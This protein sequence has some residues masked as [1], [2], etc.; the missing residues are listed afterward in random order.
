MV[1]GNVFEIKIYARA[2]N[3]DV[4]KIVLKWNLNNIHIK[5]LYVLRS[6]DPSYRLTY[7]GLYAEI[8]IATFNS[9]VKLH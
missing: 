9:D 8:F 7:Y 2:A 6:W 1:E 5:T 4:S 3:D